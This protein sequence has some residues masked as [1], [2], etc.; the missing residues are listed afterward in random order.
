MNLV[1]H[2]YLDA[3]KIVQ[4]VMRDF[5]SCKESKIIAL[6]KLWEKYEYQYI[7]KKLELKKKKNAEMQLAKKSSD[8]KLTQIDNKAYIEMK[9]QAVVWSKIDT[10]METMVLNLKNSGVIVEEE[11][12]DAIAKLLIPVEQKNK[13]LKSI[14]ERSVRIL[15]FFVF[16]YL[17]IVVVFVL[18]EKRFLCWTT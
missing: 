2:R 18:I 1:V 5:L 8:Q 3:V 16:F 9:H 10:K 7:K 12:A 17:L 15:C 13:I 11:E 14:I 6:N 4:K